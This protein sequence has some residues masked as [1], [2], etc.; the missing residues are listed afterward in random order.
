VLLDC[1]M[2][3]C[4]DVSVVVIHGSRQMALQTKSGGTITSLKAIGHETYKGVADWFFVGDVEYKDG[5]SNKDLRI[6]PYS[7]CYESD[8][9]KP[10]IDAAMARLN[11]YLQTEGEW[12]EPK[13][14]RDGRVY[15]WTPRQPVGREPL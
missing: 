11:K 8:D 6:A 2:S 7:L 5:G 4:Y 14:K 13:H 3:L 12:H 10:A 15:S 9:D 1:D